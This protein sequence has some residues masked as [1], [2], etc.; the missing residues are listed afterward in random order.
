MA[1]LTSFGS[2]G[3]LQIS[4]CKTLIILRFAGV[5]VL[6]VQA[7]SWPRIT[8]MKKVSYA[9]AAV[10][11]IAHYS[12]TQAPI[13]TILA[14]RASMVGIIPWSYTPIDETGHNYWS[15][16]LIVS[17]RVSH[18]R[19]SRCSNWAMI[20]SDDHF[21]IWRARDSSGLLLKESHHTISGVDYEVTSFYTQWDVVRERLIPLA[22]QPV[23]RSWCYT[24]SCPK[25]LSP[26]ETVH[27]L[28]K[29]FLCL[30]SAQSI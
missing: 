12:Y 18:P 23:A 27:C 20:D 14:V 26:T 8:F 22:D 3:F 29:V 9:M 25:E 30:L 7:F 28:L 24:S 15:G 10:S 5:L 11:A 21:T 2:R 4:L 1:K 13:D 16:L 19:E 6:S 17:E